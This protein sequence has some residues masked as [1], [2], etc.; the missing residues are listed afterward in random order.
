MDNMFIQ[1][2]HLIAHSNIM[3]PLTDFNWIPIWIKHSIGHGQNRMWQSFSFELPN[4]NR[5]LFIYVYN[6]NIMLTRIEGILPHSRD[7]CLA[8][9]RILYEVLCMQCL[10]V[11]MRSGMFA[12]ALHAT[13]VLHKLLSANKSLDAL[14]L[15]AARVFSTSAIETA[16]Y[17]NCEYTQSILDQ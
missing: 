14:H 4:H 13:E 17:Y 5:N 2:N 3:S 8:F 7:V 6:N 12:S 9:T 15:W 10:C 11:C 1:P 16:Q